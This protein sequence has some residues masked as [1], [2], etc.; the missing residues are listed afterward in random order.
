MGRD[1]GERSMECDM[2]GNEDDF[3]TSMVNQ[4]QS[5]EVDEEQEQPKVEAVAEVQAEA[6][7][8]ETTATESKPDT[9]PIAA[10]MAERDKRKEAAKRAEELEARIKELEGAKTANALPDFF[11]NP[12]AYVQTAISQAQRQAQD[13]LYAAL[14]EA[15][16]E[17]HADFDEVMAFVMEQAKTNPVLAGDILKGKNPAAKAYK[18]GKRL[19]DYEKSK[20]DP[21]AFRAQLR[22]E[23]L[24]ELKKEQELEALKREKE[25]AVEASIPPDLSSASSA[26][27]ASRP[28]RNRSEPLAQL[29]PKS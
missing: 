17:R 2:S 13:G 1:D 19:M 7:K 3:L 5:A 23:L 12:E 4:P 22:A 18:E 16:R 25:Q 6:P 14:E 11:Q 28:A 21:D 20:Q 27:T 10:L 8:V 9:V 29:F 24:A 15:E 26:A